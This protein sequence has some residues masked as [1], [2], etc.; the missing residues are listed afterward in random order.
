MLDTKVVGRGIVPVF[1]GAA[2]VGRSASAFRFELLRESHDLEVRAPLQSTMERLARI[3]KQP[4]D[5]RVVDSIDPSIG[6]RFAAD[7]GTGAK[8]GGPSN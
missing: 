3:V 1:S 8:C 2:R 4:G 5:D 6:F 7:L